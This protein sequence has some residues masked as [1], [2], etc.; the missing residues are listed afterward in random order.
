M[1]NE[2]EPML[3]AG[4]AG[5]KCFMINSGVDEFQHVDEQDIRDALRRL[6]GT[7]GVLLV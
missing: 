1:Q 2:L 3:S 6:Q 4:V 7:E 5:F